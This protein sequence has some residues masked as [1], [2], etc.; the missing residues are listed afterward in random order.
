MTHPEQRVGLDVVD[1]DWLLLLDAA[2]GDVTREV[3]R[4]FKC[5]D[6]GT[7]ETAEWLRTYF[8]GDYD[9][10]FVSAAPT[11]NHLDWVDYDETDHFAYTEFRP[12]IGSPVGHHST[13]EAVADRVRKIVMRD[14]DRHLAAMGYAADAPPARG[15]A[16]FMQPHVPYREPLP[17]DDYDGNR[18]DALPTAMEDGVVTHDMWYWRYVDN[19]EYALPTVL[20]L[21]GWL[22]DNGYTA[23]VTADHGECLGECGQFFHSADY[24]PHDHLTTVPWLEVHP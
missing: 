17:L 20:E 15:I 3:D 12:D 11:I 2:R 19:L 21:A 6:A 1:W 23:V 24:D 22:A 16:R 18:V 13:P 4:S 9:L 5:V 14:T 7:R 8:P 10:S